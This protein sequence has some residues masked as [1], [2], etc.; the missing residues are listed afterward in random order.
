MR[1]YNP[2]GYDLRTPRV[3]YRVLVDQS[4]LATGYTDL[5]VVL[6]SQDSAVVRVPASFSYAALGKAGRSVLARGAA[7]YRVLGKITVGT[8]Y[9]PITFPYDRAGTLAALNLPTH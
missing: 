9:G 2:N 3:K 5:N 7:P 4:E 8:P 6:P 1:V